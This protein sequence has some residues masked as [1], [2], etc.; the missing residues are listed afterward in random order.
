[1]F[2]IIREY[3]ESLSFELSLGQFFFSV[4]A[5][6]VVPQI[7]LQGYLILLNMNDH[8]NQYEHKNS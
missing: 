6:S 4:L 3:T 8:M 2:Y 1:M 7:G 5:V